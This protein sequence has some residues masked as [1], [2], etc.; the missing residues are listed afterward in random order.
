MVRTFPCSNCTLSPCYGKKKQLCWSLG[1]FTGM[2]MWLR[3]KRTGHNGYPMFAYH[4]RN[5]FRV[6]MDPS[7]NFPFNRDTLL[8]S[9]SGPISLPSSSAL[10][11]P[12][13]SLSH[14]QLGWASPS[15]LDRSPCL[16][17]ASHKQLSPR[18]LCCPVGTLLCLEAIRSACL[19]A[20]PFSS[21]ET[22]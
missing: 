11:S 20:L 22:S 12:P 6:Y 14:F 18:G 8:R 21:G 2:E 9:I 10:F 3:S 15:H 17:L 5:P 19:S 4:L 13:S 16:S 1:E 7:N